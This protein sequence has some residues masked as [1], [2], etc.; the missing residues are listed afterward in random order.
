MPDALT[1][2]STFYLSQGAGGRTNT[3]NLP[4]QAVLKAV[5]QVDKSSQ[6]RQVTHGKSG[7][8]LSSIKYGRRLP[9]E[10][11]RLQR[12]RRVAENAPTSFRG[13]S[14]SFCNSNIIRLTSSQS[15]LQP[16]RPAASRWSAG[17][18]AAKIR[19]ESADKPGPVVGNHSSTMH[20]AAHL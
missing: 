1:A 3:G 18:A 2:L 4:R 15:G 10:P 11:S 13:V 6:T 12:V 9:A 16:V 8:R 19:W 14:C 17:P 20:V 5:Y 7:A